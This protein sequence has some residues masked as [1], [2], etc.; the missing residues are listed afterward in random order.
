MYYSFLFQ[1]RIRAMKRLTEGITNVVRLGDPNLIQAGCVTMWNLCL[2][3]LQANLREHVR[4]P[5][6]I[7]AEALENINRWVDT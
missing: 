3:L 2:P 7:V 4:K 1:T 5:L 6:T